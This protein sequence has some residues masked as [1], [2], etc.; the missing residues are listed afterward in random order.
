MMGARTRRSLLLRAVPDTIDTIADRHRPSFVGD[1]LICAR[2]EEIWPCDCRQ[3]L[4]ALGVPRP[5]FVSA[6]GHIVDREE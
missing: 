6:I 5:P 3:A 1:V 4:D 2:D